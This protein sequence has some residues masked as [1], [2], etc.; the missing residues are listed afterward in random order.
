MKLTLLK[1]KPVE[2]K[3]NNPLFWKCSIFE[4]H[5]GLNIRKFTGE[6]TNETIIQQTISISLHMKSVINELTQP[7]ITLSSNK[8]T[9][10]EH[11]T[12]Y[13]LI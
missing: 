4:T 12:M 7:I 11:I 3:L 1:T 8:C 10:S 6:S 2:E 13:K 9:K 5:N